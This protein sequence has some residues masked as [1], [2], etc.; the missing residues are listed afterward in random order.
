LFEHKTERIIPRVAF[1]GRLGKHIGIAVGIICGSL[2]IGVIGYHVLEGFSWIDSLLNASMILGGM[3]PVNQL[4][5]ST[6]KVF[7]S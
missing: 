2:G 6:D 1:I 3:G 7:A 4:Q 5:T